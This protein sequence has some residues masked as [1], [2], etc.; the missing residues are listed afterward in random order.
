[1]STTETAR[2]DSIFNDARKDKKMVL[3]VLVDGTKI[4]GYVKGFDRFSISL[5]LP[6]IGPILLFKHAIAFIQFN[7]DAVASESILKPATPDAPKAVSVKP[8][9]KTRSDIAMPIEVKEAGRIRE[10]QAKQLAK[11]L[12]KAK[13]KP[14]VTKAP[15]KRADKL[16]KKNAFPTKT[17]KSGKPTNKKSAAKK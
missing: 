8:K 1:M 5:V 15:A 9:G 7:A 3:I 6:E 14:A 17:A 12:E 16:A 4:K 13:S 2:Q 11:R 10:A